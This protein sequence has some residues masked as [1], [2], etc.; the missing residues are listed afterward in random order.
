V[1]ACE[2]CGTDNDAKLTF[3]R[4]CGHRLKPKKSRV[5][6]PTP[7]TGLQ[8]AKVPPARSD[9]DEDWEPPAGT[10]GSGR[11]RPS[12]PLLELGAKATVPTAAP[13]EEVPADKIKCGECAALSPKDYRFCISC[14]AVL[15]TGA[16]RPAPT[17]AGLGGPRAKAPP[18]RA[19]AVPD[20][21]LP[22]E[23]PMP[24]TPAPADATEP[25]PEPAPLGPACGSCGGVC[26]IE[27]A[28][29][30]HCGA[31]LRKQDRPA[32]P[33]P[34]PKARPREV[35]APVD[36]RNKVQEGEPFPL[37]KSAVQ[38]PP[39]PA[40]RVA[41][42]AVPSTR[43]EGPPKAEPT[44]EVTGRLVV[45]VEDGSEGKSIDLHGRQ[46][47]IGSADGDIVLAEDRYLSPRHA[48]FF[49][50]DGQWYLRD[51]SSVNGV[52]R[53]LRSPKVLQHG[54]LVLLGLEVLQFQVVDHAER[55]LGHAIQHG[56]LVFGSPAATRR[57]R[58]CQ[59]TVEGVVRDV[60]HLVADETTI[61]RET[62]D[63]VFTSDPFMSRRHAA[64]QWD[65]AQ[66]HFVLVDLSSS[67]GTYL[68]IRE[69]VKLD[70]GDF[71]RLGQHLFRVDLPTKAHR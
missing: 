58:L 29:C 17:G 27:E 61:G 71:I 37:A 15:V 45:I 2:V 38:Q 48:R 62:G 35:S 22:R 6:P 5:V 60:Y 41:P 20:L 16:S 18:D 63:I 8:K 59:R 30:K 50:Q 68:A 11:A 33:R 54:D 7:A 44:A 66:T 32:K 26:G 51:L 10:P 67:N 52:Y 1:I 12:A 46:L 9:A 69:D 31:P 70:D 24:V 57:A 19:P 34:V 4:T 40:A 55:G 28:F 47:D 36:L 42:R 25:E 49:R 23:R 21:E 43:R 13:A 3:C 56:V 39:Q 64:V 65:E 53:R 14:G